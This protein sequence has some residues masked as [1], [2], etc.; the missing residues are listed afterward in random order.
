MRFNGST[1]S[2]GLDTTGTLTSFET[3]CAV[4]RPKTQMR[5]RLILCRHPREW[6]DVEALRIALELEEVTLEPEQK[7]VPSSQK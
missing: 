7:K 3:I 2:A 1:V 4:P 5:S 6:L